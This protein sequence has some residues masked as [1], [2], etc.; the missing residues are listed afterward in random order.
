MRLEERPWS[1]LSSL[2]VVARQVTLEDLDGLGEGHSVTASYY[3]NNLKAT[4]IDAL[5]PSE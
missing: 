2:F 5:S 4:E 3:L 1:G